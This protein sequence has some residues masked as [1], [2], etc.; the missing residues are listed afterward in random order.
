MEAGGWSWISGGGEGNHVTGCSRS[1]AEREEEKRSSDHAGTLE[2]DDRPHPRLAPNRFSFFIT[3][4]RKKTS[5]THP[6]PTNCP[7][8]SASIEQHTPQAKMLSSVS[9]T[10]VR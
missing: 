3:Y 2:L 1:S 5:T 9:R 8:L 7:A 10:S 4:E 6:P